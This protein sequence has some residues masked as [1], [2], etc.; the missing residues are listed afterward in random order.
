MLV[1]NYYKE[2]NKH[3]SRGSG[4]RISG[5]HETGLHGSVSTTAEKRMKSGQ[6]IM[7][8]RSAEMSKLKPVVQSVT[9]E[10]PSAFLDASSISEDYSSTKQDVMACVKCGNRNPLFR[11]KSGL[12]RDKNAFYRFYLINISLPQLLY[13][14][15]VIILLNAAAT[16]AYVL[17]QEGVSHTYL[18]RRLAGRERRDVQREILS[19]LGLSHRPRPSGVRAVE[20]TS[21]PLYMLELYTSASSIYPQDNVVGRS[22][23]APFYEQTNNAVDSGDLTGGRR[24]DSRGR[25][26]GPFTRDPMTDTY[27]SSITPLLNRYI[28]DSGVLTNEVGVFESSQAP[29]PSP[30]TFGNADETYN[31]IRSNEV[32]KR[33]LDYSD[34]VMSFINTKPQ[35]VISEDAIPSREL[36]MILKRH[37]SFFFNLH[38]VPPGGKLTAAKFR[39][40]KDPSDETIGNQTLRVNAYQAVLDAD[41]SFS[42]Y[43]LGS[44]LVGS[45]QGGWLVY[46][47][48]SAMQE[49]LQY[50]ESNLGLKIT[51]ETIDGNYI[52]P[53]KTGIV[54]KK[55]NPTKQ[56]FMV[57]FFS[58]NDHTRLRQH[59]RH[60][61]KRS[62]DS[63]L[64]DNE[65][66]D[67]G[68]LDDED[69]TDED[70]D[71][72]F[73]INET[74]QAPDPLENIDGGNDVEENSYRGEVPTVGSESNAVPGTG[75]T[76]EGR[77]M[78]RRRTRSRVQRKKTKNRRRKKKKGNEEPCRRR[79]L[80]VNFSDL[81]WDDWIIAPAGYPAYYCDGECGFP[82]N[83]HMNATNHAIVQSLVHL[84]SHEKGKPPKPCCSP[85]NLEAISVLYYNDNSNVVYH[86]YRDMVVKSCGC[87]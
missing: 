82:L 59:I 69:W 35:R 53:G 23:G 68:M 58:Q 10:S 71:E 67:A 41:G 19:I 87:H 13:I 7:P 57:A 42:I 21:A 29:P 81:S 33:L 80:Y 66:S 39:L 56:A 17:A 74:E 22:V 5:R 12:D 14:V 51:V 1:D 37:R 70:E 79:Q 73:I 4:R 2:T 36:R 63:S 65:S 49:W 52:K 32:E 20:K 8:G 9:H 54:G 3:R 18:H 45:Q 43:L 61:M 30:H 34:M 84:M 25:S 78:S 44:R 31:G 27:S 83:A 64:E 40:Y 86:K 47:V 76:E 16:D 60:R 28:A 15:F 85:S 24:L 6:L 50:P 75:T 72:E 26:V 62:P 11:Q 77:I 55:G 48:T 38:E 46:D